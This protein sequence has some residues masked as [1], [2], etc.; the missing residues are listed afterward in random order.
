MIDSKFMLEDSIGVL[1]QELEMP[2]ERRG[3]KLQEWTERL[4]RFRSSGRTVAAFCQNE[5]VS[6]A[7][8]Y[9]WKRKLTRP[10]ERKGQRPPDVASSGRTGKKSSAPAF[11]AVELVS[12]S[13][14]ATPS[15][16]T[17]RLPRGIEI[18]FGSD[19]GVIEAIVKQLLAEPMAADRGEGG[20]S[21]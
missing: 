7:S 17:V 3:V 5:G 18:E 9:L 8:F 21:C 16:T 15:A 12:R 6:E 10:T 20:G 19:L 2:V 4:S 1:K 13:P 11:Q 14:L